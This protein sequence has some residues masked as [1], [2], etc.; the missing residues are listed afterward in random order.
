METRHT[1]G[2]KPRGILAGERP[3]YVNYPTGPCRGIAYP[4]AFL[5][6]KD[7]NTAVVKDLI[8]KHE[9]EADARQIIFYDTEDY[10]I[11]LWNREG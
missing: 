1:S 2:L 10:L 9:Y 3:C 11:G 6:W 8:D 4:A 5:R 7:K